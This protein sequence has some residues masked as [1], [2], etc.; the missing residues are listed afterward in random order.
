MIPAPGLDVAGRE[1]NYALLLKEIGRI[2]VLT[3]I[4]G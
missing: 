3:M 1:C 2:V 4:N